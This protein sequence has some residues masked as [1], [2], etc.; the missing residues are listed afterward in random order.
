[1]FTPF[2]SRPRLGLV[3]IILGFSL[4]FL[5]GVGARLVESKH[6]LAPVLLTGQEDHHISQN[7]AVQ[8]ISNYRQSVPEGSIQAE[9][10]GKEAMVRILNQTECRGLK[11]YYARKD[12]GTPV[13]VLIGVDQYG[14]EIF[15]GEIAEN[16]IF[17]PP[18]C[19]FESS[20]IQ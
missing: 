4:L 3:F 10:F 20:F 16:G 19:G 11:I 9:I 7:E 17:C 15:P 14:S 5:V 1:M 13:L 18:I 2:A 8:L 6:D 12:D